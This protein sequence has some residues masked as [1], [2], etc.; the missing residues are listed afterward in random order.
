MARTYV[1]ETIK[2][3]FPCWLTLLIYILQGW[4]RFDV[5]APSG[6]FGTKVSIS[7]AQPYFHIQSHLQE[8]FVL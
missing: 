3:Q 6:P 1:N 4:K 8:K 5:E 7:L 2:Y